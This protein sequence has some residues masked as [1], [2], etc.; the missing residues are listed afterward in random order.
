MFFNFSP[1]LEREYRDYQR[2]KQVVCLKYGATA[3]ELQDG[4]PAQ[5]FGC[6]RDQGPLPTPVSATQGGYS[7]D[8]YGAGGSQVIPPAPARDHRAPAMGIPTFRGLG[9]GV[10]IYPQGW[11]KN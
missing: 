11:K 10:Q 4:I 8:P 9:A 3:R 6:E 7:F 1:D 5:P 2:F